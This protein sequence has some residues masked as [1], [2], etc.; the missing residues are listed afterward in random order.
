MKP[1]GIWRYLG[2]GTLLLCGIVAA[3]GQSQ[4]LLGATKTAEQ[5]IVEQTNAFRERQ[6]R[7]RLRNNSEL[8]AAAAY[9]AGFMAE[10]GE[11]GHTADGKRPGERAEEHGYEYCLVAENIAFYEA[12]G[13]MESNELVTL[14]MQGWI[15]SQTHRRNL[16]D[17]DVTELGVAIAQSDDGRYYA[18]Q[19]F[20]RPR[21]EAIVVEIKNSFGDAVEYRLGEKTYE[22]EKATLR[23]HQLCRPTKLSLEP[24]STDEEPQPEW[25]VASGDRFVVT[26]DEAGKPAIRELPPKRA[27]AAAN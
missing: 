23:R 8:T 20:G 14:L 27:D 12:S 18:V 13:S 5:L 17:P 3:S 7:G 16:L 9:F 21:S 4:R 25:T 10:T 2:C 15:D 22:L 24:Q 6:D 11:Y 1:S 26:A 19:L